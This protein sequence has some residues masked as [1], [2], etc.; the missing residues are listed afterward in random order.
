MGKIDERAKHNKESAMKMNEQAE[1]NL[2]EA[3]EKADALSEQ[4]LSADAELPRKSS[5]GD[6]QVR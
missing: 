6:S 2:L 5:V 4:G 3:K 1:A